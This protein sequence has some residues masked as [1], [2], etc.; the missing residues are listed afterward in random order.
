[1]TLLVAELE[2]SSALGDSQREKLAIPDNGFM[3]STFSS[4]LMKEKNHAFWSYF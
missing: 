4:I 3:H 2:E 1:M